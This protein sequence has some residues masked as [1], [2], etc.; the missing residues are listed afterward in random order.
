MSQA[1]K[2]IYIDIRLNAT[3]MK[4]LKKGHTA[5]TIVKGVRYAIHPVEKDK[6]AR[7]IAKLQAEIRKLQSQSPKSSKRPYVKK[8]T[9]FWSNGG[10][11]KHIN[12]KG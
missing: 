1:R 11:V 12:K 2:K 4:Q 6:T 3:D 10:N 7:R 5:H 9:E 8:N